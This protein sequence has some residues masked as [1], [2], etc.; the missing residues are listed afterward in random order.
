[1]RFKTLLILSLFAGLLACNNDSLEDLEKEYL[2]QVSI[3]VGGNTYV[4]SGN[5]GAKVSRKG[6]VVDW[7]KEEAVLSFYFKL[8]QA[9]KALLQLVV[10]RRESSSEIKVSVGEIAEV[11]SL[12]AGTEYT[13]SV[14]LFDLPAGYVQVDVQGVSK[15]GESYPSLKSLMVLTKSA[16]DITY[17]KDNESNRFYWGRRG[18]SV[19]LSYTLPEDKNFK[20]FYNEITVPEGEDPNGSYYMANGFGEGYFGI[21][22]NS[23][24]ERRVLFSVWSPF[25]T[26]NPDEIPEDQ[27]IKL[28]KKG[29]GVNTG[30]FGNEGSGGQS[31]FRYNWITGNTYRFLNSVEPDGNGNTVYTAYFYAPEVGEWKLIASFLRPQTDTWYKRPHSF[32]ENFIDRNGYIGRKAFYHNQWAMDTEGNWEELTEAKFTGD[33]IARRGYRLDYAGGEESGKFFLR[34]GGYFNDFVELNSM[35]DRSPQGKAP[36]IDFENLD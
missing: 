35:H 27:R 21:Q 22:A 24:T 14:G 29:E 5:E 32:L 3:P 6:T 7:T 17:V 18:P 15:S 16:V 11:V 28:L 2:S 20:W 4:T 8:P 9:E 19:H 36:E 13:V 33:D 34:N 25:H 10:D 1:M 26:N 23:D 31:F 30:E 12:E